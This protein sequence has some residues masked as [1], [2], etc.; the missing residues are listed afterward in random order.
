MISRSKTIESWVREQS[1]GVLGGRG[2]LGRRLVRRLIASGAR[3]VTAFDRQPVIWGKNAMK[4][5]SV[6]QVEGNI[7]DVACLERVVRDCTV[8]FHLAALVHVG[9]SEVEPLP[10]F[11]TNALGT[12]CV[13]EACRRSRVSRVVYTS[14]GHVYGIP[15]RVPIQED[16]P[17]LPLSSYAASK[18]AGE[19][20]MQ[21]F[22]T[23]FGVPCVIAR[24]ANVY[25]MSF[26]HETLVGHAVKQTVEGK[27]IRLRN[28]TSIRDFV[29]VNDVVEAL[30]RLAAADKKN[31]GFQI[32]N[33]STGCGVSVLD[34]VETLSNIAPELGLRRPEITQMAGEKRERVPILIL[35]NRHL[36]NLTGWAPRMDTHQGLRI[37]LQ[38]CVQEGE[39]RDEHHEFTQAQDCRL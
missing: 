35:D 29:H 34:M 15:R 26:D 1:I 2:S 11:E 19:A 31:N 10:Y 30:I 8:V 9:R 28:L 5:R 25:G 24:L 33:V 27:G 6:E 12:A 23:G 22:A 13:L 37:A 39:R 36:L 38:E 3:K 17:T 18:L 21:G 7:L 4:D 32:V 16:H 14:T 20:V